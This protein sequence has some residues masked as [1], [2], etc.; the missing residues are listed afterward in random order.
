MSAANEWNQA[1]VTEFRANGGKVGGY[2][3]GIPLLLL[4]SIGSRSGQSRISPLIRLNDNGRLVV[5]ASKGGAP[6][7]PDWY[8]NLIANPVA[9]VEL[10]TESFQVHATVADPQERD[11]IYAQAAEKLPHMFGEYQKKTTRKIPVIF[12]DRIG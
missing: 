4:T 5:I 8:H 11:R 10:G 12:L 9:T 3:E 1:T 2:F 7:H 6:T